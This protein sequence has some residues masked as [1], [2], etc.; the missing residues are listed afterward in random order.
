MKQNGALP[1]PFTAENNY[2][3]A[4]QLISQHNC[5]FGWMPLN[6]SLLAQ[7]VWSTGLKQIA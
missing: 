6:T 7:L 4:K 5:S 1:P 2:R 3:F